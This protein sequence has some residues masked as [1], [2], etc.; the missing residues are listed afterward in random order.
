MELK[1]LIVEGLSKR[2]WVPKTQ[3]RPGTMS[4]LDRIRSFFSNPLTRELNATEL[5]ALKEVSFDV[6]H[7]SVLGI[8]GSN[9]AGKSTLLKVLAKVISP[10]AGRIRGRGRVV[11]LI[12]LGAG[13]DDESSA[14]ENIYMNAAMNGVSRADVER[15]FD[16]IIGFAEL[17]DSVDTPLQYYSTGMYLRLAFSVAINMDP[18]IL[19]ADEILAVGDL[20]FQERCLQKVRELARD[21]GLTVLFVSHDMEAVSR[22]CDR[23]IWLKGG[24][25]HRD[26]AS[27]EVV[28]E[29]Q[30]AAWDLLTSGGSADLKTDGRSGRYGEILEVKLLSADGREI[31]SPPRAEDIYVRIRFRTHA[32]K[33]RVR[34]G[35]DLLTKGVLVLRSTQPELAQLAPDMVYE[36]LARIPA[37]LLSETT[38]SVNANVTLIRGDGEEHP[39]VVNK[40]LAF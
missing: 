32:A 3:Q 19:L 17:E 6:D 8:I 21:R 24:R 15:R 29:Y 12:E 35:F 11:S 38:Y 4:R 23:V 36:A 22:I 20:A 14:R 1:S 18:A 10:T 25:L 27:E 37:N 31:G 34:C 5:W 40:A 30:N 2:Y 16:D 28:T 26:G 39:L 33:T 9:G 13:F 7:G